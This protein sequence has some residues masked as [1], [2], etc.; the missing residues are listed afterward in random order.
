MLRTCE[1]QNANNHTLDYYISIYEIEKLYN[2]VL[3]SGFYPREW[4]KGLIVSLHKSGSQ[5][6]TSNYRGI[7]LTSMIGKLLTLILNTDYLN[8]ENLI[9]KFQAGFR[10]GYRT[11]D[12]MFVLHQ[13]LKHYRKNGK[14]V[15]ISL[16]DFH[17][18]FDKLWRH[19]LLI[20]L[21]EKGIGGNLYKLLNKCIL[22]SLPRLELRINVPL[23]FLA[24]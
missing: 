3:S 10:K 6:D 1:Q 20:K 11:T 19:G 23:V 15:Y 18:A 7:T 24:M 12:H 14:H 16:I 9:S 17:K 21:C 4:E 22:K 2:L 8:K 5:T 13:T